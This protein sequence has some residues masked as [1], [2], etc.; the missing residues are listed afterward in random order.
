MRRPTRTPGTTHYPTAPGRPATASSSYFP[1]PRAGAAT[2]GPTG[3]L[4]AGA[5]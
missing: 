3:T 4:Q 2:F 5:H 1:A